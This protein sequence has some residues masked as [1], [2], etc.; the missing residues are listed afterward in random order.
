M[1]RLSVV[2]V[3]IAALGFAASASAQSYPT[4]P[5]RIIVAYPAGQGTDIATRHL[6]E[7]LAK[8]LGQNFFVENRP[9]AGGN[10]GTEVTAKAAPDGYTLTMGT[11]ASHAANEFMYPSI[12]FD[13]E[14]DFEP[15]ILVGMLPMV[16]S[17]SASSAETTLRG[18]IAAAKAKPDAINV[19]LPS[20]TARVVYEML[21]Q[22][23]APLFAVPYRGSAAALTDVLGGQVQVLIDTVTATRPQAAAG[24]LRA[25]AITTAK[26][27][28]LMPGV[29]SVAEQGIAGFEVTAWNA[30]FAPRGTPAAIVSLLN[31]E[32]GKALAQPETRQRLLQIG[33]EPVGG[34]PAQ[35]AEFVKLE[36]QKWGQII[37]SAQIKAE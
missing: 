3:S 13:P 18:L 2:I 9:G 6:G 19:A 34:T 35:L 21:R 10:V 36:R 24:K 11:N 5:V 22:G 16:V 1:P 31:A 12:G 26:P 4:K 25:L 33:F 37:R 23:G 15:V 14:R 28:E 29:P 7:Q 20:T 30:L 27:S 8:S 32:M 17:V